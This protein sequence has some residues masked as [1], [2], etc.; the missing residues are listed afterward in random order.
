MN[1]TQKRDAVRKTH[2]FRA[3]RSEPAQREDHSN[4]AYHYVLTKEGRGAR[5]YTGDLRLPNSMGL[6]D[7]PYAWHRLT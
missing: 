6:P 5:I 4:S 1:E 7:T 2:L 3:F